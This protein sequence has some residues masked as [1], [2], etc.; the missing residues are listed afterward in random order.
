MIFY[1][2]YIAKGS[3]LMNEPQM[4]VRYWL[5]WP[6]D[7]FKKPHVWYLQNVYMVVHQ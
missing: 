6:R 1:T 3:E 7:S 4:N 2:Q 5:E